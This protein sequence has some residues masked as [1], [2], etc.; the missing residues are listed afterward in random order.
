VQGLFCLI[1]Y[2]YFDLVFFNI[3]YSIQYMTGSQ[4]TRKIAVLLFALAFFLFLQRDF[5]CTIAPRELYS[6]IWFFQKFKTH[7]LQKLESFMN[8]V[9]IYNTSDI[10]KAIFNRVKTQLE[11]FHS[12]V[13]RNLTNIVVINVSDFF[14]FE[15]VL[16]LCYLI[17]RSDIISIGWCQFRTP[18][19]IANSLLLFSEI[20]TGFSRRFWKIHKKRDW[21]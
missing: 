14:Y 1:V 15:S 10:W 18:N 20:K 9:E 8:R 17:M 19:T 13:L 5:F 12:C 11:N 6:P 4:H 21:W 3:Q 2:L 16:W 7:K